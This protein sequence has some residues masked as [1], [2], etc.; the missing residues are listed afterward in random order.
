MPEPTTS[1]V[2]RGT[3]DLLILRTL[4][5]EAQHGWGISQRIQQDVLPQAPAV[6]DE[7]IQDYYDRN[8]SQFEAPETRD[9]RVILTKTEAE[10]DK[11]LAELQKDDSP[12]GWQAVAKKYSIDEA[13]KGFVGVTGTFNMA[14]SDHLGLDLSAFRMLEIKGGNWALVQ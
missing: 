1:D 7:E 8:A 10:A 2:L 5:L 4:A 12:K 3:L 6:T 9:V 14:A 11:A 13:T